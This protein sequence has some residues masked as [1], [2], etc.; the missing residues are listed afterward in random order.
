MY[1]RM[2]LNVARSAASVFGWGATV[3]AVCA[4]SGCRPAPLADIT[5]LTDARR[6]AADAFVQFVK[7]AD[8]GNRAVMADTDEASQTFAREAEVASRAVS[9]DV[10]HLTSL[11][12]DLGAAEESRL[13]Q[14]FAAR[15]A[16]YTSVDR[17][18]LTLAVEN[19]NLKAQRLSF[20]PAQVAAEEFHD[21]LRTIDQVEGASP[22]FRVRAT[23]ATA[24]AAAREVQVLQAPH[25]AESDEA[26]MSHLEARAAEAEA[27]ARRSLGQ[28]D[29]I[30]SPKARPKLAAATSALESFIAVNAQIVTLSRRNSNVRSLALSLGQ[31]RTLAAACEERL[32]ALQDSLA[33]RGFAGSR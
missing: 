14:E 7:T 17:E 26:Q 16:E 24:V 6:S 1:R 18:I 28:L 33:S 21:A 19:T 13:L 29:R 20:G 11:L 15:F 2:S 9:R 3:V 5:R 8:A 31:K 12:H 27:E 22:D 25:I 23:I 4:C 32:Q 30:V 10:E